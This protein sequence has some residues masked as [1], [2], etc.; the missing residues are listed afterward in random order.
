MKLKLTKN[1]INSNESKKDK[2]Y[3]QSKKKKKTNKNKKLILKTAFE[4]IRSKKPELSIFDCYPNNGTEVID[5]ITEGIK[6]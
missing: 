1:K 4:N 6:R 3:S 5:P 2:N